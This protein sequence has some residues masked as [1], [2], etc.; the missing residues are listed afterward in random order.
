MCPPF[1]ATIS[2]ALIGST[3]NSPRPAMSLRVEAWVGDGEGQS[4]ALSE[5]ALDRTDRC[6]Q[7]GHVVQ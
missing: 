1:T 2:P 5:H 3:A 4:S 6:I 7:I